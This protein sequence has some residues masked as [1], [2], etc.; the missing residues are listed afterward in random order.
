M[1]DT[2]EREARE[3]GAWSIWKTQVLL[4]GYL[5]IF[6]RASSGK[7]N[8]RTF[9]DCFAGSDRNIDR[10]TKEEV[11]SSIELALD[12]DPTFTH[13]FGFELPE[14]ADALQAK[15]VA[16]YPGRPIRV[17]G[18]DCNSKI[19]EGLRWWREQG[20][21]DGRFGPVWGPTLAY[22]DPNSMQLDWETVA[23]LANFA[24]T[25][26]VP[27]ERTRTKRIELLI[28]FPTGTM[29]RTLPQ[30]GK[31]E[32]SEAAKLNID[33]IFGGREWRQIYD[34]Q[35]SGSI[36]GESSWIHYVNQYRYQL[37]QLGYPHTSAIEVRNT[38]RAV[39]Y[40]MVFATQSKA[41]QDIMTSILERARKVLPAM[42]SKE[43]SLRAHQGPSLFQG[44]DAELDEFFAHPEKYAQLFSGP[45]GP[46][47][48]AAA[49][50]DAIEQPT[51]FG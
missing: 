48:R 18:G 37:S 13:V 32:A 15:L 16:R 30:R 46:Y 27:H 7:A 51:L 40:H 45:T 14:N 44:S 26:S 21:P 33:R 9:I 11:P 12:A 2:G 20:S 35:R 17:I 25:S 49:V 10:T 39:Q 5:P 47:D 36:G 43:K 31:P 19:G 22:L 1:T 3:W 38:T 29:R 50:A 24:M 41:G 4:G 8:H 6:T 23:T 34:D 42:V 28:L